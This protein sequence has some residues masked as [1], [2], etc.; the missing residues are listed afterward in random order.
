MSAGVDLLRPFF[1]CDGLPTVYLIQRFD[2]SVDARVAL[3]RYQS[4]GHGLPGACL[5]REAVTFDPN[6]L[7]LA[8]YHNFDPPARGGDTLHP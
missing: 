4:C 5:L 3:L 1:H 8:V 7:L 2:S 6:S